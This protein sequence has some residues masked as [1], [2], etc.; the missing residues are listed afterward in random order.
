MVSKLN[1]NLVSQAVFLKFNG[2]SPLLIAWTQ[3]SLSFPPTLPLEV[4]EILSQYMNDP[5]VSITFIQ[6]YVKW[7]VLP[8]MKSMCTIFPFLRIYIGLV[9]CEQMI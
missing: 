1:I 6:F 7:E 9:I 5:Q 4:E 8:S 2:L 3:T